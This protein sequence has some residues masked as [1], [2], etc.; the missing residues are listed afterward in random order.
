M[1]SISIYSQTPYKALSYAWVNEMVEESNR[2]QER[3]ICNNKPVWISDNLHAAL[4]TFRHP[5]SILT[6][7]VDFLCINQQDVEER[8]R[9]VG[10]MRSIYSNCEEVL[11]W[12]GPNVVGDHVGEN[13]VVDSIQ[14]Y[15]YR[16][17]WHNYK[18]DEKVVTSCPRL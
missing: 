16:I 14:K 18:R 3:I 7:W 2:K 6:L 4:K 8:N 1:R 17:A 5:T 11:I 15:N 13:H 12:L 9:Q 10:K